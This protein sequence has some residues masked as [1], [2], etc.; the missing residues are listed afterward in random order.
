MQLDIPAWFR[1]Y[2]LT[3]EGMALAIA[4]IEEIDANLKQIQDDDIKDQK[5]WM[6]C[7]PSIMRKFMDLH[8]KKL[9]NDP[10]VRQKRRQPLQGQPSTSLATPPTTTIRLIP[11]ELDEEETII[12]NQEFTITN[13]TFGPAKKPFETYTDPFIPNRLLEIYLTEAKHKAWALGNFALLAPL[14][15]GFLLTLLNERDKQAA[16]I[17]LQQI[18]NTNS[19]CIIESYV[20]ACPFTMN[21]F[22]TQRCPS[23]MGCLL[24]AKGVISY[25]GRDT[26]Y[27]T[28]LWNIHRP[29][30]KCGCEHVGKV[31]S[32]KMGTFCGLIM[33]CGS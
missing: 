18:L 12:A 16:K 14:N 1:I 26:N 11:D 7:S 3:R 9:R 6:E 33:H 13:V 19:S 32:V 24:G 10:M 30:I 4:R 2:A 22:E 21:N 8:G 5:E 17:G 28:Q 29:F 27:T 31:I 20:I 25:T 23:H 15:E